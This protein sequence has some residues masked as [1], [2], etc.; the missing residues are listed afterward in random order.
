MRKS[1]D[2]SIKLLGIAKFSDGEIEARVHP[3]M[4]PAASPIA[5]VEGVYNAIQLVGDAV[6]DVVLY[7]RGAGSMPTGSAVVSDVIAIAPQSAQ[8]CRRSGPAG[9]VSAGSATTAYACDRWKKSV[10]STIFASWSWIGP[11]CLSQIA[12]ESWAAMGSAFLRCCNKGRQEGQTVPIVIMTHMAK[13]RMCK[14]ALREINHHAV[15]FR[16]HDADS[17]RRAG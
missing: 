8:G 14:H 11:A 17:G 10:R 3:T 15:C 13:E 5:K 1:L 7:G 16:A 9:V 2:L 4:V 12:G 6:D